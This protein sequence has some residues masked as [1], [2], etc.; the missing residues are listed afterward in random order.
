MIRNLIFDFGK[1]LV[2]YDY[3]FIL[4]QIFTTHEQSLDFYRH[5]MDDKWNERLDRETRTFWQIIGD[6]QE[7]MPQWHDEIRQFGERYTEF[8]LG[9]IAGMHDLLVRMKAEGYRLYGL[10]NWCSRVH[11]TMG[12]YDIF[13]LLDG[14]IVSSE[15][16]M[17]KPERE[18]YDLTC[19]KFGLKASECV[20]ADDK[21]E[22]VEAARDYGMYAVWFKD[23]TQYERELR[24]IINEA[25]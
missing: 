10:T 5:L 1:V 13:K 19:R 16:H 22:N 20:F 8:V 18:I 4:D 11:E 7:A 3:F 6:M 23:A 24:A 9:E 12:Q 17:V 25:G 21:I 2:D 14:R 15:E